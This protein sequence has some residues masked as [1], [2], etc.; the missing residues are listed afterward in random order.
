VAA[1]GEFERDLAQPDVENRRDRVQD[2]RLTGDLQPC[3]DGV[4]QRK[5]ALS[6]GAARPA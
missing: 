5:A 2:Q 4:L 1:F 6:R 3:R